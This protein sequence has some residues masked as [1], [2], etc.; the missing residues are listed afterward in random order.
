M[1]LTDYPW[2][3]CMTNKQF[4]IIRKL[5][6]GDVLLDHEEE[7]ADKMSSTMEHVYLQKTDAKQARQ[8]EW[9]NQKQKQSPGD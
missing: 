8:E 3:L 9:N 2:T 4:R 5:L 6:R 1:Y 7:A